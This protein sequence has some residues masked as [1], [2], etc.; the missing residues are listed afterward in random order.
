MTD[1]EQLHTGSGQRGAGKKGPRTE[2]SA[3]CVGGS[4]KS[5]PVANNATRTGHPAEGDEMTLATV[6]KT[7]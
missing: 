5:R 7:C 1:R 6:V 3:A 2:D 4:S